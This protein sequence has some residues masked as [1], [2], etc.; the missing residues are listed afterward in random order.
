MTTFGTSVREEFRA[1]AAA[2]SQSSD[3]CTKEAEITVELLLSEDE[4]T[5]GVAQIN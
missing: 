2:A 5:V 1:A 3:A 4:V